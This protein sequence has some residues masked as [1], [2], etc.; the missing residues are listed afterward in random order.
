MQDYSIGLTGL[1]AAQTGLNIVGNNIANAATEGYHRQ[2]V[3]LAPSAY[4]QSGEMAIGGGVDVAGVTRMI[5]RLIEGELLRQ[6]ASYAQLSEELSTL[7]SVETVLGEYAE[8]GG[9]NAALDAFFEALQVL[10]NHPLEQ[11]W[12]HEV[13]NAAEAL[14]G[15][16]RRMASTFSSLED[17]IVLEARH[18]ADSINALISQIAELNGKIQSV[19][20]GLTEA[21]NLCDRRD[22]LITELS[23]LISVETIPREYGVVDVSIAGLP[24]VTGAM[25]TEVAV[26]LQGDQTLGLFAVGGGG[27]NLETQGGRLGGLLSLKN[28]LLWDVRDDLDTVAKAVINAINR[29]H[30]EGLGVKGSFTE[31]IGG[32]LTSDSLF[33]TDSP[34]TD[35]TFYIRL[36]DTTTGMTQ[37]H[38]VEVDASGVPPDTFASIA[39]KIDSIEG[40][41]CSVVSS[42]LRIFTDLGY[43]FD[44]IRAVAPEPTTSNLTTASPP[45]ISVS[46]MYNEATNQTLRFTV[47]GSGSI[48]N[49]DLRVDVSNDAGDVIGALNV[50][51]GYAAGDVIELDNGIKIALGTGDL[52]GGDSFDVEVYS[53]TDTSGF[54]AA[55]G[56]NTFFSGTSASEVRVSEDIAAIPDRIATATGS[57]LTDNT[58]ALQMARVRDEALESLDGMTPNQYYQ[59]VVADIG[60]RVSLKQAQQDNVESMMQNLEMRRNEISGVNINDEAAQLLVFE[61][62]FQAV[63]KYLNTLQATMATMMELL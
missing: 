38:A 30:V 39:A 13:I 23:R 55:A 56:M 50:G 11:V 59:R 46:G 14:A 3:E 58:V 57:G 24:A 12:R 48:G 25:A 44:F 32:V 40:L 36:R 10:A 22:Q 28:G 45:E 2:R 20:I 19:G 6:E 35:G 27:H 17:Q 47:V 15:E 31:L 60:Q 5:D 18:A 51:V 8:S 42:R 26:E 1:K 33:E 49:G 62:M 61:K 43:E 34:I 53:T 52:N 7:N 63:A 37:R 54:L 16:F 9:L 41:N 21:T 4:G 29:Y